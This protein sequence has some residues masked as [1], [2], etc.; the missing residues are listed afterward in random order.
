[1][2]KQVGVMLLEGMSEKAIMWRVRN[3]KERRQEQ[4]TI[5]LP[6]LVNVVLSTTS[7]CRRRA[8]PGKGCRKRSFLRNM[9]GA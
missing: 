9:R 4:A 1:M 5:H 3:Q 8:V 7:G 2:R 6:V